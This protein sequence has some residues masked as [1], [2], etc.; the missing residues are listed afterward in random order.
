MVEALRAKSVV[1]VA[2]TRIVDVEKKVVAVALLVLKVEMRP[3]VKLRLEPEMFVVD[4]LFEVK[5]GAESDA[6]K[7]ADAERLVVD[8]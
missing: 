3:L 4:A 2:L 8:A 1:A 7:A 6:M 5:V